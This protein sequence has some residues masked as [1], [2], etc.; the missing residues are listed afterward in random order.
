MTEYNTSN[1]K[2]SNAQLDKLKS[3]LKNGIG[4]TLTGLLIKGLSETIENEAKE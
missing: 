3:R 2:L 4:V 1:I